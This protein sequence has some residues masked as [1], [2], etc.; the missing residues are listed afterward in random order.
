MFV[1]V[2]H[3]TSSIPYTGTITTSIYNS[4]ENALQNYEKIVKSHLESWSYGYHINFIFE[5]NKY[6][7][8]EFKQVDEEFKEIFNSYL[9]DISEITENNIYNLENKLKSNRILLSFL[10]I[11]TESDDNGNTKYKQVISKGNNKYFINV[12]LMKI[13]PSDQIQFTS[14]YCFCE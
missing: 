1:I 11:K 2:N 7:T 10:I 5:N 13:E 12:E 4:F 14:S 8:H 6:V 3:G 9:E